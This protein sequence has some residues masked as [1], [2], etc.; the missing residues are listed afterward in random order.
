VGDYYI[1]KG[2]TFINILYII[3]ELGWC[4][5]LSVGLGVR[6]HVAK[7]TRSLDGFHGHQMV[8]THKSEPDLQVFGVWVR[9]LSGRI[10]ERIAI[11]GNSVSLFFFAFY[12]GGLFVPLYIYYY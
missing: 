4:Y 12:F 5:D 10:T 7:K 9:R 6:V 8:I 1:R 3:L 2:S 11:I